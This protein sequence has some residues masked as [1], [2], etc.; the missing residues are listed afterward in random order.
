MTAIVAIAENGKVYIG[1]D[2]AGISREDLSISSRKDEKVFVAGEFIIGFTSSFRMGQIL[3][4]F[5]KCPKQKKTQTDEEYMCTT[6]IDN[7]QKVFKDKNYGQ[8][9]S[10]EQ[11]GGTFIVGYRGTIYTIYDDFQIQVCHENYASEGC[12]RFLALGSLYTTTTFKMTTEN[13]ITMALA[14]AETHNAGVRN[15]F[16]IKEL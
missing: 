3:K 10:N 15:P 12:G 7:V 5:L 11:S 14:A 6:F 1:A 16:I 8:V 9:E 13:K 2:S 4:Y